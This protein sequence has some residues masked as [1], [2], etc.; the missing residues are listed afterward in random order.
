MSNGLPLVRDRNEYLDWEQFKSIMTA[1]G[2]LP[3]L[4]E[5]RTLM[6]L[7]KSANGSRSELGFLNRAR[8]LEV[9]GLTGIEA[10]SRIPYILEFPTPASQ[11]DGFLSRMAERYDSRNYI[12]SKLVHDTS[13]SHPDCSACTYFEKYV[14]TTVIREMANLFKGKPPNWSAPSTPTEFATR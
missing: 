9:V 7:F 1:L 2:V 5:R 11:I 12:L 13:D 10:F 14:L 3:H 6:K 4:M 8:F